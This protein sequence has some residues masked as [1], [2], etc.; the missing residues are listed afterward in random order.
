MYQ[1]VNVPKV[2]YFVWAGGVAPL[3]PIGAEIMSSWAKSCPNCEIHLLVDE[4]T[5][6]KSLEKLVEDYKV[7]FKTHQ[8]DILVKNSGVR[9]HGGNAPIILKD[10]KREGLRDE[11]VAYEIEQLIPNYGAASD[12]IRYEVLSRGGCYFDGTDVKP[13]PD[14]PLEKAGIFSN[15]TKH[16]LYVDYLTQNPRPTSLELEKFS[17]NTIGNDS[18]I[19][20]ANNPLMKEISNAAKINYA[21]SIDK[22]GVIINHA[23]ASHHPRLITIS[24]TGPGLVRQTINKILI[25]RDQNYFV[26]IGQEEVEL[27]SLRDSTH[28]LCQPADRNTRLWLK[29]ASI[30]TPISASE[31]IKKVC[32]AIDFEVTHFHY[33]RLDYHATL[34]ARALTTSSKI[35]TPQ[36]AFLFINNHLKFKKEEFFKEI[37]YVPLLGTCS[38]EVLEVCV[39]H[40]LSTIFD[41]DVKTRIRT[42]QIEGNKMEIISGIEDIKVIQRTAHVEESLARIET[43]IKEGWGEKMLHGIKYLEFMFSENEKFNPDEAAIFGKEATE[44][45]GRY[46]EFN[47]LLRQ[48]FPQMEIYKNLEP[49]ILVLQDKSMYFANRAPS[50]QQ[51]LPNIK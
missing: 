5:T 23:H 25:E 3:P 24:R 12:L 4:T 33:L 8:V 15:P 36:Q 1:H 41:F 48:C 19:A 42:L 7:I 21:L 11:L 29:G 34:L 17:L 14:Y 37:A 20:T 39:R 16:T 46:K 45:L 30:S 47:T 10:I 27:R 6:G 38:T 51:L 44:I 13:H 2:I 9:I 22:I 18:F 28:L 40:K 31:A 32:K 43:D 26:K 49:K 50:T 35:Y